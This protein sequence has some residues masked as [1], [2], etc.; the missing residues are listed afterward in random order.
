MKKE[1]GSKALT[2]PA[3]VEVVKKKKKSSSSSKKDKKGKGKALPADGDLRCQDASRA[4]ATQEEEGQPRC[5]PWL[6]PLRPAGL[7]RRIG[8]RAPG[9]TR[10]QR[11][12]MGQTTRRESGRE[13]EAVEAGAAATQEE[14]GQPRCP[15]WLL[16]LRPA[17]L[18]R[19]WYRSRRGRERAATAAAKAGTSAAPPPPASPPP[20]SRP[21]TADVPSPGR[22]SGGLPQLPHPL[23][24]FR[25]E[26][27]APFL[28]FGIEFPPFKPT[29]FH[30]RSRKTLR[31]VPKFR[32]RRRCC[33]VGARGCARSACHG[34]R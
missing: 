12:G 21:G 5:P 6:L 16:P 22:G 33:R 2:T 18:Y 13:D 15:P 27:F 19:R 8:A 31:L 20:Y 4:A 3:P 24:R 17:G 23:C 1:R 26:L 34:S 9:E 14:E 10:Y 25:G 11:G 29:R 30:R 32:L 7:Y 28:L